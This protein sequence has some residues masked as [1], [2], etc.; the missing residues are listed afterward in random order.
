MSKVNIG[1][2][3]NGLSTF[4]TNGI[5]IQSNSKLF[6]TENMSSMTKFD[7]TSI[8]INVDDSLPSSSIEGFDI[9]SDDG[10]TNLISISGNRISNVS[11]RDMIATATQEG[12]RLFGSQS[13]TPAVIIKSSGAKKGGGTGATTIQN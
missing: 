5:K 11:I 1:S 3:I 4:T 12:F 8:I 6:I 13:S 2:E 10:A 7:V 9:K